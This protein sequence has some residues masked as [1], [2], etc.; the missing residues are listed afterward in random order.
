MRSTTNLRNGNKKRL[1]GRLAVRRPY[2]MCRRTLAERL[3]EGPHSW[4]LTGA[5]PSA[6][7]LDVEALV[8]NLQ[9]AAAHTRCVQERLLLSKLGTRRSHVL[10]K[11]IICADRLAG[12]SC[13]PLCRPRLVPRPHVDNLL[14]DRRTTASHQDD[15]AQSGIIT[16]CPP[17]Y[18][19]FVVAHRGSRA[20][21][22]MRGLY[23]GSRFFSRSHRLSLVPPTFDSQS[24]QARW[25]LADY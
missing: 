17:H 15:A 7:T 21:R 10:G 8:E 14:E 16:I 20:L 2:S 18:A 11:Q 3:L 19:S 23:A 12:C 9:Y 25:H 24:T 4:V 1:R 6:G 13:L 5:A 22:R